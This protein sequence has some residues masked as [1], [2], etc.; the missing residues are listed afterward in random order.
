[1]E[2]LTFELEFIT[3]AFIGGADP[4]KKAELRPASFVGLMRYWFRVIAGAFVSS[5]EELFKLESE[6]FGNSEKAG[7]VW[8]RIIGN[9]QNSIKECQTW[10]ISQNDARDFGKVYL[11]YGN[12]LYVNFKKDKYVKKFPELYKLCKQR[13]FNKGNITVR[14]WLMKEQ[15]ANLE[16]MAPRHHVEKVEALLFIISQIGAIG[17]RNRRGWGSLY[18][19]P[20]YDKGSYRNWTYWDRKELRKA[21]D[22]I[23]GIPKY[24]E[25]YSLKES[26]TYTKP[27]EALEH[28][29]RKYREFRSRKNPDYENVK[30]FLEG[31]TV[32][33]IEVRRVYFGLPLSFRFRSLNNREAEIVSPTGRF[34][35]PVRFRIIRL[36]SGNF[37]PLIIHIKHEEED[38]PSN[39]KIKDKSSG[40]I[41]DIHKPLNNIFYKF[42]TENNLVRED[43]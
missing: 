13:N 39:L 31:K 8:V 37:M 4:D 2:R 20:L 18:L 14:P 30:E 26:T 40:K 9:V 17:S 32:E 24:I 16:V 35:S 41:Q 38:L 21:F 42:V 12:I 19:K 28:I 7:K 33:N 1:M 5:T 29:G 34:A 43:I 27:M 15:K 10:K 23:G 6:L 3:P 36:S 11:G 22:N 25:I